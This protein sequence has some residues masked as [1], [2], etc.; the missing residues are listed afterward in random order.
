MNLTNKL[1]VQADPLLDKE[2]FRNLTD[3]PLKTMVT[4]IRSG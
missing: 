1:D 2:D 3:S 4:R